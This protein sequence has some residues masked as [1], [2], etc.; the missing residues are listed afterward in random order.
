MRMLQWQLLPLTSSSYSV[1]QH[2][3]GT[4][5]K[6][7]WGGGGNKRGIF[8]LHIPSSQEI[9]IWKWF[10][11]QALESDCLCSNSGSNTYWLCDSG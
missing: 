2:G 5:Q 9:F 10:K 7:W 6:S 4:H 3:K 11:A 8:K 1:L